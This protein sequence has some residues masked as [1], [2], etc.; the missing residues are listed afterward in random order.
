A[1]RT[2]H[3]S[4]RSHILEL[5]RP[6]AKPNAPISLSFPA[7]L[8]RRAA[9]KLPPELATL[10]L[11]KHAKPVWLDPI[12]LTLVP[13][14]LSAHLTWN[15]SRSDSQRR[16]ASSGTKSPELSCRLAD[17]Q[18][19]AVPVACH[20]GGVHTYSW[21]AKWQNK[22]FHLDGFLYVE[23]VADMLSA[24]RDIAQRAT[25]VDAL[26]PNH[27]PSPINHRRSSF[28][29]AREL[30]AQAHL[31]LLDA[32]LLFTKQHPYFAGHI[33]DDF[34]TWH[35]GGGIYILESPSDP[36][37]RAVRPVIDPQTPETLG[38]GV[39]RDPEL[40]WDATKLVFAHKAEQRGMT[41]IYEI[42]LDGRG[43]RRLTRSDEYHDITPC[44]LPDGRIA[45][46]STRPKA[47]V[48]CFNSGVATLHTMNPDGS[49]IRAISANNV[50]EFDPSILPDGRILY[51]RWEYVDKTALY[52]QSLW[53]T[54]PDGTMETALFANNLAKPTALLDARPVPGP[55]LERSEGTR[56]VA[57]ALTPHN[58]QAVGAIALIDPALGKNNLDAITNF[59]PEYPAQMDQG[60]RVGPCDPWPLSA[61]DVLISNNAL[62]EHGIL[63]LIDRFGHRELVHCDPAISC[64][65]PMLVKPRPVPPVIAPVAGQDQP[66]RFLVADIYQGL[67][68]IPRGAVK[69]LRVVEETARTSEVPP[70]GRWWNQAF[71]VSWQGAYVVKNFLGTVPVHEDGSAYFE[72]PPGRALYF[73]ALDADGR[74]VQRMRTFVQAVPGV[75]RSCIGC[76][77]AKESGPP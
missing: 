52:M 22:T 36:T 24:A 49:D 75:T 71:L 30:R 48:P 47:R 77:E 11:A 74:E 13:A 76:H 15:A 41:S 64:Y 38:G 18:T 32:P 14:D 56:L 65:A 4:S 7:E 33:Y 9:G 8:V 60:L 20:P 55:A 29:H 31:R 6:L 67:T 42:G 35:P 61:D 54:F 73:Q 43:L 26:H 51:G 70:G 34:Y 37:R 69:R 66:G 23:P 44:Y 25:M 28:C 2:T 63:E 62:G 3:H 27:Q 5:A 21:Q 45:F 19:G 40:F 1:L 72:A 16:L 57:A 53:T 12:A 17:A 59:T 50:N 39:Y 58:G 10:G 46:L 68:G